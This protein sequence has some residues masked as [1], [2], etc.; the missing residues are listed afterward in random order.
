MMVGISVVAA[1]L[2]PS[3]FALSPPQVEVAGWATADLWWPAVACA[4]GSCAGTLLLIVA[5]VRNSPPFLIAAGGTA[6]LL[7]ATG[8]TGLFPALPTA[9]IYGLGCALALVWRCFLQLSCAAP[10]LYAALVAVSALAS[11]AQR[12]TGWGQI[13]G[14]PSGASGRRRARQLRGSHT[15]A[16]AAKR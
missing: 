3:V 13:E 7:L 1:V 8:L 5:A 2:L 15:A 9:V 16:T 12:L 6:V 14:T 4:V 10:L 11:T